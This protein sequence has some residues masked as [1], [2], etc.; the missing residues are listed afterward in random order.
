MEETLNISIDFIADM[1]A[2]KEAGERRSVRV[3]G[4]ERAEHVDL[5]AIAGVPNV[6]ALLG[7]IDA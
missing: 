7:G 5:P 4:I 2:W 3:S 6:H 1:K